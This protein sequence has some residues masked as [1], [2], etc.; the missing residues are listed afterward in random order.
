MVKKAFSIILSLL[1]LASHMYLAVGTHFCQGEALNYQ[2][3]LGK[4]SLGCDINGDTCN[5]SENPGENLSDINNTSCCETEYQNLSSTDDFIIEKNII[6]YPNTDVIA[7]YL[8]SVL[9]LDIF[10]GTEDMYYVDYAP[11]LF[12]R[13]IPVL[14]QTFLI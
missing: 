5:K 14:F 13:D 12:E 9:V 2:I 8:F 11:P 7:A 6:N 3:V 10:H 1:L 4:S